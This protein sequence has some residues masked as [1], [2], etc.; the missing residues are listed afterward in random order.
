MASMPH[1]LSV[2]VN[3]LAVDGINK[4]VSGMVEMLKLVVTGV[5]QL[6]LFIVNYYIGT[7][8]CLIIAL[9]KGGLGVAVDVVDAATKEINDFI[10]PVTDEFTKGISGFQDLLKQ[11]ADKINLGSVFPPVPQLNIDAPLD[12]LKGFKLDS[13]GFV[14]DLQQ[15]NTSIP[16]FDEAEKA[17]SDAL[18]IPFDLVKDQITKAYGNYTFDGSAFP[19][20]EKQAL[21]FCSSNSFLNDFFTRLF[22]IVAKAK[23]AFIVVIIILAILAMLVMGYLEIRRWRREKERARTFTEHGYDPM[24]VVYMASRPYTAGIGVKIASKFRSN[25]RRYL[26]VR[27]AIA[28]GT[29]LPAL[30]VLS[31]ASGG[32]R[33]TP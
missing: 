10:G 14:K 3:S 12:K 8:A 11:F 27:W 1:Y 6:L 22:E 25:E 9:I 33:G 4:A 30:F 18:A 19:V 15:L 5:K 24:D 16:T 31:L 28:Y 7:W 13:T 26:L 20:A 32:F 23:I 2:G 21:K 17:A 29:S